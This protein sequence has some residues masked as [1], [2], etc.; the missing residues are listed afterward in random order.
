MFSAFWHGFYLNYYVA[1]L[2]FFANIEVQKIIY[3]R[4]LADGTSA[5]GIKNPSVEKAVD[6]VHQ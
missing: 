3:K 5:F 6:L 1:F 4:K 2:Y